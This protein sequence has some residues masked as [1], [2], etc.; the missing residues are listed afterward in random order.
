MEKHPKKRTVEDAEMGSTT[1]DNISTTKPHE[2]VVKK[3]K[4]KQ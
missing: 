3:A 4:R 2:R 1:T